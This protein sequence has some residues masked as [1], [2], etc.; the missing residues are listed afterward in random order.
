V[1]PRRLRALVALAVAV[2]VLGACG[3]TH[4]ATGS[5][6]ARAAGALVTIDLTRTGPA[7]PRSFLGLSTE[8]DSVEAYTG[9]DGH[10]RAALLRLL[11]PLVREAGGL[12]LR[13][14]GDTADQ[15]WWNPRGRPRPAGVLQDLNPATLDAVAWL[16]RGLGG[17]VTLNVNLALGDPHNALALARA[18]QRRLPR[19]SLDTLE[20][21][22]EPDLY[23]RA[24]TFR[25][26]GHVHRR[27]RK[28]SRYGPGAYGRDVASYLDVL[29]G[30][31]RPPPR[32]AVAGFAGPAWFSSL[33]RLLDAWGGR[34]GALSG[35][36]Y[37]LPRCAGRAPPLSWLLTTAAS[38]GRVAS[39]AP[40]VAVGHRRGLPVHVTEL[41]SAACGGRPGLS[42][43]FGAALWL[44]DTLFALL[45]LGADQ[46]D[47]HT[48]AHARYAPF[49]VAGATA[50]PRPPLTAMLA[51]A[52]A[53]PPGSRLV[54]ASADLGKVRA[55]ATVDTKR[56]VRVA[57]IAPTA[58]RAEVVISNTSCAHAWVATARRRYTARVCPRRGRTDIALPSRAL[59]VLTMPARRARH[60]AAL[61]PAPGSLQLLRFASRSSD[62][63][64]GAHQPAHR[65]GR[66]RAGFP[67]SQALP[68]RDEPLA[69]RASCGRAT[70]VVG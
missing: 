30:R 16:A 3:A 58:V 32:L 59:A 53:A 27:L 1:R 7:V 65:M 52:R 68:R 67:D 51:F 28:R 37:A 34:A 61:P 29:S 18:A 21:G 25:V 22:N 17:P 66:P 43:S 6:T 12:A 69:P 54:A 47:V 48:W 64:R 10:R 62:C 45:R 20:L 13:V 40:L 14:G 4:G 49:D 26:P 63:T 50:T 19:G 8:W 55:W 15:A 24:R 31:L 39:L 44:T 23:T 11:E 70:L 35:H 33:R 42:D 60:G 9:A 57:L 38:R 56:T 41:N 5:R 36:L 46:A 2:T